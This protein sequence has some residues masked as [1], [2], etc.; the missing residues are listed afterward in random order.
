MVR[1]FSRAMGAHDPCGQEIGGRHV[2]EIVYM[3]K[4]W[5]CKFQPLGICSL[6]IFDNDGGIFLVGSIDTIMV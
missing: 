5:H 3:G 2:V 4:K 1:A 6:T